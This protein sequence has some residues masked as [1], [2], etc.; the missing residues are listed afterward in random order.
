MNI[1]MEKLELGNITIDVVKKDIKNIHLSV[2]PPGGRVRISAPKRLDLDTIRVFAISKLN[3]IKKQQSRIKKQDR[4]AP[5][6]YINRESHY[7]RGKQYLLKV[8]EHNAPPRVVLRHSTIDMYIRTNSNRAKRRQVLDEWYRNYM[9]DILPPLIEKWEQKMGV[10]VNEFGIKKMK[11]KWGTCNRQAKRIW[12]NLELAKKPPE[13]L[14][15]I[16]VHEMVHLL[17]RYHNDRFKSLMDNF[18]PKWRFYR[19]ELNRFPV[20]HEDWKY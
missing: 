11:T 8:I 9:K 13:C 19:D 18:M 15:Y 3:W 12:L 17:E 20:S 14:E 4:E 5:R 2:H 6:D 1:N 10:K 16:L 7:F